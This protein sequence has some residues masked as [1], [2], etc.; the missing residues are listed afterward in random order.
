VIQGRDSGLFDGGA[1]ITRAEMAT[2]CSR[3]YTGAPVEGTTTFS[4][5]SGHWAE[6]AIQTVSA[7]GWV[8]GYPDGTFCPDNYITRAEAM[9]IINRM[10]GRAPETADDLSADMKVWS[11]ND[12][13]AWYY[14]AVQEAT[15]S[16]EHSAKGESGETWTLISDDP[17]WTQYE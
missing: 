1:Y 15:N 4:D 12:P 14:L 7:L 8:Q 2:I 6:Q 16:H 9:T 3:L 13:S 5:V 10:L 11:D 17:D